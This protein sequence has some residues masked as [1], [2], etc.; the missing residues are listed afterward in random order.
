MPQ[1]PLA[2]QARFLCHR[3][4][5]IYYSQQKI[6]TRDFRGPDFFVVLG[7][8]RKPRKSWMVWD[9]EGNYPNVIVEIL[10]KST[11]NVDKGLKKQLYQDTFRTP[12]YFCFDP[13][14]L[15]FAGFHLVEG[16]YQPL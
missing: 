16:E 13:E 14:T 7:T 9:E 2:G 10:S 11:A 6:K 12:D 5:T 1:F 3:H 8:E 15:E 4:L